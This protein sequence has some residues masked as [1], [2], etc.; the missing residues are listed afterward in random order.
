MRFVVLDDSDQGEQLLRRLAVDARD[1]DVGSVRFEQAAPPADE[2]KSGQA[3][4]EW[5]SVVVTAAP[6]L[7]DVLRLARDWALR[8][9]RSVQVRIGDD[10][11]V[12]SHVSDHQQDKIINEFFDRHRGD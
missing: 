4:A 6:T 1:L 8:S 5:V 3:L 2:P 12:L 10:E 7:L 9:S 11:L